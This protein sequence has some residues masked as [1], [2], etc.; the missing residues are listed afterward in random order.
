MTAG[1]MNTKLYW[2]QTQSIKNH[3]QK[4]FKNRVSCSSTFHIYSH[5]PESWLHKYYLHKCMCLQTY[6]YISRCLQVCL[7]ACVCVCEKKSG[8]VEVLWSRAVD[9]WREGSELWKLQLHFVHNSSRHRSQSLR[10]GVG[11]ETPLGMKRNRSDCGRR[12]L[13]DTNY[14]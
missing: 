1:W 14:S 3:R 6:R 5:I 2:S 4:K 11:T 12:S 9:R 13:L 10:V 7:C 8:S